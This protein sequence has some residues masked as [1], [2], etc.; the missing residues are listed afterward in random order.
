MEGLRRAGL[1]APLGGDG[2]KRW[3]YVEFTFDWENDT[4]T[5]YVEDQATGSSRTHSG[6]LRHGEDVRSVEVANWASGAWRDSQ[7]YH[8]WV[9]D[10]TLEDEDD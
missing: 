9:D 2:Y 4:Y 1:E 8:M 7:P 10:V 5:V 6:E 3:V